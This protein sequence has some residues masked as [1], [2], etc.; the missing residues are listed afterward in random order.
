MPRPASH[1]SA[2][3]GDVPS[4][5]FRFVPGDPCPIGGPLQGPFLLLPFA[6]RGLKP[7][8]IHGLPLQ[9]NQKGR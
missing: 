6:P 8:A 3:S 2:G 7:N 9:G 1:L 4:G 5:R